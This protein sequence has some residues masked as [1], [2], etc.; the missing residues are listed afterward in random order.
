[1]SEDLISK[2]NKVMKPENVIFWNDLM[3]DM[4]ARFQGKIE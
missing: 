2:L 1:M 4:R 3:E